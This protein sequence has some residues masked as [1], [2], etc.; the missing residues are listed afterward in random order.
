MISMRFTPLFLLA[1]AAGCSKEPPPSPDEAAQK[2]MIWD[3]L[4]AY[5]E[6][7]DKGDVAKMVEVLSPQVSLV[8]GHE[9]VCRGVE[10]VEKE[11]AARVDSYKKQSRSTLLGKEHITV[12]GDTALVTYV[13][14]VGTQRGIVTAACRKTGGKW[15]L[16]HIHDSWSP[17]APPK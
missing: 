14:S 12:M 15:T 9:D 7:G 10:E 4:K 6:A 3:M 2:Q 16:V 17:P 5:H 8:R 13:A 11:L 1:L